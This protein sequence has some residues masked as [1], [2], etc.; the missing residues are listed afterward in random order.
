MKTLSRRAFLTAS[1]SSALCPPTALGAVRVPSGGALDLPLLAPRRLF[2]PSLA[3]DHSDVSP[4]CLTHDWLV[5]ATPHGDAFP[6]LTDP[7]SVDPNDPRVV[8]LSL[9]PSMRFSDGSPVD[10]NAVARAWSS[11]RASSSGRVALALLDTRDPFTVTSPLSVTLRLGHPA[12]L[13]D[14]LAAPPMAVTARRAS[15][16]ATV[17]LGPFY[18]NIRHDSLRRNVHCPTGPSWLDSVVLSRAVPRNEELRRFTARALDASWWGASLYGLSRPAQRLTGA[19]GAIVGLVPEPTGPL[20]VAPAARGL[21][22]LL[23]SLT[24]DHGPLSALRT[25]A[26]DTPFFDVPTLSHLL[27]S[28]PAEVSPGVSPEVSPGAPS[29]TPHQA[30]GATLRIARDPED[31]SLV[32]L[33]ERI[34]AVLD[35]AGIRATTVAPASPADLSLRAV[36]PISP[37]EGLALATLLAAARGGSESDAAAIARA[38]RPSRARAATVAWGRSIVSVLGHRPPVIYLRADLVGV[39]FDS[40]GRLSLSDAWVLG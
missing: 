37:D 33:A 10:A 22:R 32:D 12:N 24:A 23:R 11:A 25:V 29:A 17:G 13:R 31:G 1:L 5:C 8:R 15:H 9:R 28:R 16:R 40:L 7:P 36:T 38:A 18:A 39:H 3:V 20:A 4:L 35:R 2:D 6:L 21:E 19:R 27:S 14:F 30:L 34:V 26:P